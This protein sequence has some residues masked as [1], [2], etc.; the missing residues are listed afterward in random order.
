M[1]AVLF[2]FFV[3]D[4]GVIMQGF[5]GFPRLCEGAVEIVSLSLTFLVTP[6]CVSENLLL[7][8][9]SSPQDDAYHDAV[10]AELVDAQR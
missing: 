2:C 6:P 9:P 10:V 1:M 7:H 4:M 8:A 3:P 5:Q